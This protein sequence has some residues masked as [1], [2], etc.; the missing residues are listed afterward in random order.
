MHDTGL[1]EFASDNY[2]GVH[3]D[4][5]AAIAAANGGH[6]VSYGHDVHTGRLQEVFRQH[7]GPEARAYPV[8]TGTGANVIALL[9]ACS[10]WASVICADTAHLHVD[11]CGAPEK[12]GGVKLLTVP[13]EHGKLTVSA[14]EREARGFD[15][16]HR[17]QPQVV[18]LAQATELGTVYSPEEIRA[19][20]EF[21]HARAMLVHV[22][23]ARLANA[24]A[25]TGLPLRAFT[26]DAGADIVSF[27]GTKNGM[28]LGEAVVVLDPALDHGIPYLRKFSMQLASK[29][30]FV[31][32]Q[33]VA[34]LEGDLWLRNARQANEMAR[35]LHEGIRD[36]PGVNVTNPVQ[37]NAVFATLPARALAEL[38]RRFHFY[39]WDES[40]GE[41]RWMTSF[42]TT[43]EDVHAFV[44]AVRAACFR[45]G[46]E[47]TEAARAGVVA[48]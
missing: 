30:R 4:V 1:R 18:S 9:A 35:L 34:L 31:S 46:G 7:F 16:E 48:G 6:Q 11:E 45:D 20:A 15:D 22:D 37:S 27:G 41:V 8:L 19:I 13:G 25:H 32:A 28:L 39:D 38:H 26:T 2:A 47:D 10:R 21:A 40:T 42:D 17:A 44:R 14:L 23:G 3:P 29:M 24:A 33:F 12:V 43:P 36:V 5:L